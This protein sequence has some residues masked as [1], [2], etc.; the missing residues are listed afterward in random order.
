[1]KLINKK[2]LTIITNSI[3]IFLELSQITG[4]KVLCTGGESKDSN[5][6]VG[7]QAEKMISSYHVDKTII[8]CKGIDME[9][10]ITDSNEAETQIK[11]LMIDCSEKTIL[12]VD[13]SKFDKIS[14]TKVSNLSNIDVIVAD[15][16]LDDKWQQTFQSMN[17]EYM[18]KNK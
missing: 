3:E 6:L 7:Y 13:H 1:M 9:K 11:K 14:F 2:N 5:T 10:G 15:T 12:A 16:E 18:Y 4:W 17:I 8:S